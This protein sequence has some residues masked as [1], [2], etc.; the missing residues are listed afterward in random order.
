MKA[1]FLQVLQERAPCTVHDAL[2]LPRRA[3]AVEDVEG[4]RERQPLEDQVRVSISTHEVVPRADPRPRRE[5]P[6][7]VLGDL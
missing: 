3:G 5:A 6:Q 1:M 7:R 2:R 4:M